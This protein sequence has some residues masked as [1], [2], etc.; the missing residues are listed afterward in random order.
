M[1]A[2]A[3]SVRE[4][5]VGLTAVIAATLGIGLF[6]GIQMPLIALVLERWGVSGTLIGLNG[7]MPSLAVLLLGPFLAGIARRLGTMR[8]MLG[9]LA[10]GGASVL[11]MPYLPNLTAWFVLRFF[12]GFGLA[13]PWIVGE[14]WINTVASDRVRARVLGLYSSS[15]FL[16]MALG[17]ILLQHVETTSPAPFVLATAALAL[18]ALPLVAARRLA[19][20]VAD[21]PR[22]GFLQV[23]LAAPTV[24]G[25]ALMAGLSEMALFMLLP[26]YG[27]RAGL[28][29]SDALWLLT[30]LIAGAILLQF[31]LGWLADRVDRRLLLGVMA[32]L[33]ALLVPL[34]APALA[35]PWLSWPLLFVLGG[36]VLGYYTV[37][38]AL[39][40]ARFRPSELALANAAFVVLYETGAAL[41][42]GLAGAAMDIWSPSGYLAFFSAAGALFAVL[43]LARRRRAP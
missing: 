11:A 24:T 20:P 13:L 19:P 5:T 39:L 22:M 28:V 9:G 16:G 1:R 29:E 41:G 6:L 21:Y 32:A 23:V 38:L 15:L 30:V 2:P 3:L 40:G 27:L 34:L 37:G 35:N 42:P 33:S 36:L 31:P 12:M 26:V 43:A 17:P 8:S 25:A 18:A 14:T 4:R 7:A 10:I